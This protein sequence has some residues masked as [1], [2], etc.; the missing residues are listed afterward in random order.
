M[1]QPKSK[2]GEA[3]GQ[4][5]K[6]ERVQ[7]PGYVN[8]WYLTQHCSI[9]GFRQI[10]ERRPKQSVRETGETLEPQDKR[11]QSAILHTVLALQVREHE[12]EA[13]GLGGFHGEEK[14]QD[15]EYRAYNGR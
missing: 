15:S 10:D 4:N 2:K 5:S 9:C 7:R 13:N 1:M 8:R 6:Q 3:V 11:R 14:K 12:A